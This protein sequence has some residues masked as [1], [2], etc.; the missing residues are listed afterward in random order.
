MSNNSTH[1][2]I[3]VSTRAE[4][5]EALKTAHGGETIRMAAGDYGSLDMPVSRMPW[6]KE[7]SDTVT[8]VSA[9]PENRATISGLNLTGAKNMAFEGIVFDY[10][11]AVG[12]ADNTKPFKISWAS[13]IAI[14]D[15]VFDGDIAEGVGAWA[16]GYGTGYGLLVTGGQNIEVSGS[17]FY[18]W[19][20][21]AVFN[22][23]Q[24]IEV[25][26]ND[27]HDIRS[28]G[29]DF[30]QVKDVLIE[31]N[32]L[33][34]FTATASSGGK[35]D[36][37]DMIQF[38][39]SGTT[40]PSENIV[41][42]GNLLDSAAGSAT[43]SIF[44]R[45]ELVDSYG[46][47]EDF[48]YR[49]VLIEENV[50]R[51]ATLHGITVGEAEGV[52]VRNNTLLFNAASAGGAGS[53]P[54]ILVASKALDV[55]VIDNIAHGF[56]L[57]GENWDVSGNLAVQRSDPM[58]PHH[59]DALFVNATADDLISAAGIRVLPGGMLDGT[60]IGASALAWEDAPDALLPVVKSWETDNLKT[61]TFD[62]GMTVDDGGLAAQDGARFI[63]LFDD[64]AIAEGVQVNHTFGS[65]GRHTAQ[66]TVLAADGETAHGAA[67]V[68]IADPLRLRLEADAEGLHDYSSYGVK[69]PA[70]AVE[71][72]DGLW[73]VRLS[74]DHPSFS[75]ARG[76]GAAFNSDEFSIGLRL[77][78]E[79]G[80][81][82]FRLHNSMI[83][84]VTEDGGLRLTMWTREGGTYSVSSGPSNLLDGAWHDADFVFDSEAGTLKAFVD[85]DLLATVSAHGTTKPSEYWGL[86]IGSAWG[87][88]G[89]EGLIAEIDVRAEALSD[90]QVAIAAQ[91]FEV[92]ASVEGPKWVGLDDSFVLDFGSD[93][94]IKALNGDAILIE[95]D[96]VSTIS[97]DGSGDQA[98]LG[99]LTNYEKSEQLSVMMDIKR[100]MIGIG[101]DRV[102]WNHAKFGLV[103]RNDTVLL[104]VA[105]EDGFK[106]KAGGNIELN[107]LDWHRI[108]MTLD[109]EADQLRLYADG[110]MIMEVNDIGLDFVGAGGREWG[111]QLGG[112]FGRDFEGQVDNL[113]ISDKILN[114]ELMTSTIEDGAWF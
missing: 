41:I 4:L 114:E 86:D 21:G 35:G 113:L 95:H 50:I 79:N 23:V 37:L 13:D 96:G 101:D 8:M 57:G 103:L 33:H 49:N 2:T 68:Y 39:T 55:H 7:Y 43:Q 3:D 74:A 98:D 32:H 65:Y 45:N 9:D 80:G 78:G 85:G 84:Y 5:L 75:F 99:R 34:D 16:D 64:G 25:L 109:Q 92:A 69:V 53:A 73:A 59:Y 44:M 52:T 46:K 88:N 110:R 14:R 112:A 108:G 30:A 36:H 31:S 1:I 62:A 6:L 22:K 17:E 104:Q 82:L 87:K 105:T 26:G 38:W 28:D 18:N 58:S 94:G 54:R 42:R 102:L 15:C 29:L 72:H 19:V 10:D 40:A 66:L 83:A 89:F 107:D 51:N 12:E 70:E 63:W 97:F 11:A 60:G 93:E 61:W 106:I 76:Q 48:Y 27:I 24:G 90:R 20:R 81:E 77:S 111:W 91:H 100:D 47:G 67:K 56:T 71:M